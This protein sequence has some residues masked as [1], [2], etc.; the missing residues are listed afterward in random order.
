M[1][2]HVDTFRSLGAQVVLVSFGS[3]TLAVRWLRE[4]AAPFSL[5]LDPDRKAYRTYGVDRSLFRSWGPR[6]IM[7]YARL[8]LAG[9]R[10]RGIQGN[11]SQLGGDFIIDETGVIRFAHPSHDPTDRPDIDVLVRIL[12][13]ASSVSSSS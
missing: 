11:S 10:W 9:R 3:P 5:W 6:A 13:Q 12:R 8:L 7:T 2:Q 1:C 4:T